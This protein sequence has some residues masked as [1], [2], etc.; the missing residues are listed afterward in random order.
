LISDDQ[1]LYIQIVEPIGFRAKEHNDRYSLEKD[2][3]TNLLT[4]RFIEKFC[5][6]T[7]LIDWPKVVTENSGNYDLD[8]FFA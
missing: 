7:G 8:H 4:K 3:I 5:D 2:K 6:Q 1:D